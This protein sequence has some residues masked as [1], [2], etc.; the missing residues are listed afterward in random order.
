M[1]TGHAAAAAAA[2]D[3]GSWKGSQASYTGQGGLDRAQDI[4]S[5][6]G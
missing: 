6:D 5:S 3:V 4:G 2:A 1:R